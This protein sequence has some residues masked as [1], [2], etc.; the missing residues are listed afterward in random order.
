MSAFGSDFTVGIEEELLLVDDAT[1][2]LAP[3]TDDVLAAMRVG[4]REAGHDAYAAQIEL[5]SSPSASASDAAGQ[6]ARLRVA[7]VASGATL[8]GSGLHPDARLG[9]A[10]LVE[11]SRYEVVG[12][13]LRGLLRRTPESALHVHVGLPDERT[14]IRVF[15]AMRLHVPLLHG[16]ATNSPYWFGVDSGLASARFALCRAYPGRQIP[17]ALVDPDD[18]E[19]LATAT[20]AAAGLPDATFL[21][22]DLRLH[23]AFGTIELREMDAQGSLDHVAALGALARALVV[24]AAVSP[25]PPLVPSEALDWS[26]FRAA[27]DGTA[28]IVLDRDSPRPLADVARDAV[29]RLRP[30]ARD[31][32]DEDALEGIA[33]ILEG[34]GAARQRA[35]FAA[36]GM[37]G[38]V[39]ELVDRTGRA[40]TVAAPTTQRFPGGGAG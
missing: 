18:L 34:G 24:E 20:L 38:L 27:R 5:R 13:Q 22:W 10:A 28:A 17:R 36:G 39:R 12:D 31:V 29:V 40:G 35:A 7:A 4:P 2:A 30:L 15:N 16:L 32:G 21:W 37:A 25:P 23:P 14:A 19:E 26:L 6:L 1:L 11:G 8:L 33:G 3:V 9:E